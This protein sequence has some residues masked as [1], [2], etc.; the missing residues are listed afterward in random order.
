MEGLV[1]LSYRVD[2]GLFINSI[3]WG[4]EKVVFF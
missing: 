3:C 1:D 2:R 4:F